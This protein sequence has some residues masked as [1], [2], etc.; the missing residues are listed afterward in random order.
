MSTYIVN[1]LD[2]Q[3]DD[4]IGRAKTMR[5]SGYYA[6]ADA[7]MKRAWACSERSQAY[8]LK[9][10]IDGHAGQRLPAPGVP[11]HADAAPN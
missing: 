5:A 6:S 2:E 11:K 8:A 9:L 4:L 1:R 10:I 3:Y 7:L